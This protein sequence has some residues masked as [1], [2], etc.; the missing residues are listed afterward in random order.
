MSVC[1][2]RFNRAAEVAKKHGINKIYTDYREFIRCDDLD[3]VIVGSPDD[4]HHQIAMEA[5]PHGKHVFCEN[6][7]QNKSHRLKRWFHPL[8]NKFQSIWSILP[9]DGCLCVSFLKLLDGGNIGVTM[10][11][12]IGYKRNTTVSS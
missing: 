4:L 11:I 5:L 7:W 8:K 3:A 1:S 6:R 12:S 9:G 2:R 10:Y